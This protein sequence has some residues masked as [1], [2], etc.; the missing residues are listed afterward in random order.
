MLHTFLGHLHPE[1]GSPMR[2]LRPEIKLAVAVAVILAAALHPRQWAGET[3]GLLSGLLLGFLLAG[4]IPPRP[5]FARLLVLEPFAAGVALMALFQ[6][7]GP[8]FFAWILAR[9]TV[10]LL[11]LVLLSAT[12]PFTDVIAVLRRARV[13]AL[14]LTTLALM[15]RYLFLLAEETRRM[16]RAQAA[17]TFR[18]EDRATVWRHTA[19]LIGRL[20]IRTHDRAGRI[21]SAML[22]RGWVS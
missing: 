6:P 14:F 1:T 21:Y 12:T 3:L 15:Y 4:R 11:T 13:P 18:R 7:G 22:A 17:R 16:R 19:R 5:V 20:F 8:A 9:S 10:C 2:R